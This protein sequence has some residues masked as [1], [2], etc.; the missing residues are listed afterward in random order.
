M[1]LPFDFI[2]GIA[3]R[4][5]EIRIGGDDRASILNSMI[6][7]DRSRASKVARESE[8]LKETIVHSSGV[9]DALRRLIV[10]CRHPI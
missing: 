10:G 2:Q 9:F 4:L 1:G 3:E 7:C 8:E 6:A 5:Q